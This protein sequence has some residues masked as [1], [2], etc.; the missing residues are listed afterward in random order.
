[1]SSSILARV[2]LGYA[3]MIDRQRAVIAT[4]LTLFPLRPGEPLAAGEL[5]DALAGVWP[6]GAGE[7]S[8]NIL[9]ESL[10]HDLMAAQPARHLGVEVPAFMAADPAHTAVI[11]A[12]AA[13]GNALLIKGRP[14]RELPRE[15]LPCFRQSIIDLGEDR[16]LKES[17]GQP[18]PVPRSIGFVQ[19]GIHTLAEM[20]ASFARGAVAVLGWPF[21]D[22]LA[23]RHRPADR[24]AGQP[25]AELGV[26]MEM[27]RQ[28]QSGASVETLEST[29]SQDPRLAFRLLR[30]LNSPAFGLAVEVG[31]F[32]HALML[33]GTQRLQRWLA[34]LLATASEDLNLRPLMFAAVRRGLLMEELLQRS[35][36]EELAGE[37]FIC[38]VFSLLDQ[39]LDQPFEALFRSLPVPD[40]VR[41]ALVEGQ[42]PCMPYL[43][44]VQAV[45]GDDLDPIREAFAS[46][47]S[48]AGETN[49]ALLAA[50][51]RATSLR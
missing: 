2:A 20:E 4:R 31:S 5:L 38:G 11:A 12:L 13:R 9:S 39:L 10:L 22:A 44:L 43:R 51:A 18:S 27:M 37:C 28:L 19:S 40:R 34:L 16:R 35:G 23:R 49:E 47:F 33:L 26:I 17:A 1:M 25:S 32:R 3:P 30:Y 41:Q 42:G 29:L 7:V 6:E 48:Y 8:L 14:S 24:A 36:Y 50:L 45:E 46:L 15:L 21:Q